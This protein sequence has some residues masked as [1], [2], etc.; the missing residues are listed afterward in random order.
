MALL[1][2]VIVAESV[3]PC[4]LDRFCDD[5]SG[6]DWVADDW[7]GIPEYSPLLLFGCVCGAGGIVATSAAR[8]CS[9]IFCAQ[10]RDRLVHQS[11][12]LYGWYDGLVVVQ[13]LCV[14]V[15]VGIIGAV[16]LTAADAAHWYYCARLWSPV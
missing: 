13:A 9:W 8:R 5:E 4:W 3:A 12:Q 7:R 6:R 16:R 10:S 11:R 1:S 14:A 2:L 15:G